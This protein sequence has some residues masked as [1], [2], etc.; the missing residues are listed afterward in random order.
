M[1]ILDSLL[2][3]DSKHLYT[4]SYGAGDQVL[5]DNII[6]LGPSGI[7]TWGSA[8][9][10]YPASWRAGEL[11]LNVY[12]HTLP[13]SSGKMTFRLLHAD[14]TGELTPGSITAPVLLESAE[15]SIASPISALIGRKAWEV[16]LP[17]T[18]KRYLGLAF[19]IGAGSTL[20]VGFQMSAWISKDAEY[21]AQDN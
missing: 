9:P 19:K 16:G 12:I 8:D 20:G 3:F 7:D 17:K 14:S 15:F 11:I 1:S 13:V 10:V 6:D 18:I 21:G 2:E 5:C 4:A